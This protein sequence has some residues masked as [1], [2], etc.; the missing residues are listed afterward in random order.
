[1]K[2]QKQP[3]PRTVPPL[4][5]T[6]SLLDPEPTVHYGVPRDLDDQVSFALSS[7]RVVAGFL[8]ASRYGT[9]ELTRRPRRRGKCSTGPPSFWRG[10]TSHGSR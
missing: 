5:P 1:M 7:I 10:W 4:P 6:A 8:G 2:K 3:R 9:C